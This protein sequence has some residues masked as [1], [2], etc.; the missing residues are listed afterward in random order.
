MIKK[1]FNYALMSLSLENVFLISK[2]NC[3]KNISKIEKKH[4]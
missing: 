4:N 3:K 1:I 2:Q